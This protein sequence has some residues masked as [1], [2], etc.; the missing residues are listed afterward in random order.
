MSTHLPEN[1][2]YF[3]SKFRDCF[4]FDEGP[5]LPTPK[6][7]RKLIHYFLWQ[8]YS[9]SVNL[10]LSQYF[11]RKEGKICSLTRLLAKI[12]YRRNE[13]KNNCE[14]SNLALIARGTVFHHGGVVVTSGSVIEAE[15][16]LYRNVILGKKRG[17][18]PVVKKG[19]KLGSNSVVVGGISVG[20]NAIVAP[21]AVVVKSVPN[22]VVVGGVPAIYV[23]DATEENRDF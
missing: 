19:A 12:F 4:N 11:D 2:E 9:I 5:M 17:E 22:G 6:G 8:R 14:I 20:E 18:A 7:I 3:P 16:H 21:G 1:S 15:V 10:R 13:V 23:C